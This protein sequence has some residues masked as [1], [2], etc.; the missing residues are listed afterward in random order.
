MEKKSNK[1]GVIIKLDFEKAFDTVNWEFLFDLLA[2]FG[3][4]SKWLG[5][6]KTCLSTASISILVNGSPTNEIQL[7][8]GLRQG[9]PLSPFLFNIVAEG[10][11]KLLSRAKDMGLIRGAIVGPNG[12]K[13]THL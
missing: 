9:D 7:E 12:L 3:F 2:K 5:W 6:I 10:L 8:R 13:F 11:N 1:Q 4:G